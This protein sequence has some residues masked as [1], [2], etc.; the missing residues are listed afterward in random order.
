MRPTASGAALLHACAYSFRDDVQLPPS[1]TSAEAKR[2]TIFGMLAEQKVNGGLPVALSEKL[3][4]LGEEEGRKLVAMWGHGSAWLDAHMRPGWGAERAFV[5]DPER[6]EAREIPRIEHRDYS[7]AKPSEIV[8][9]TADLVWIDGD[10]VCVADWKT[11]SD[12]A[13]DV[14]AREQLEWLALMACRTWGYDAAR[15]VTLKVTEHGI[16]ALE[17]EVLDLFGLAAVAERIAADVARIPSAEPVPGPHCTGRYCRAVSVCPATTQAMTQLVP[18]TAL[19]RKEW[20]YQPII[21]SPDHLAYMLEIRP[22]IRKAC[23]QV[24]AAIEAY[25]ASGPVMTS[26]GR[27]IKQTFRTMSRMNQKDLIT[28]AKQKGATDEEISVCIHAANEGN[29]VR[30][31]G[32]ANK[33]RSK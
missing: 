1:P 5:Y 11:A 18:D 17:G 15:I 31:S 10:A 12:G 14:D 33:S 4:T 20:R 25:V 9:G 22:L 7:A 32:G 27:T 8:A 13:P 19:V 23:E 26:D 21:D 28:L 3:A 6:D 16:E 30:I 29:G 24:D 2:G